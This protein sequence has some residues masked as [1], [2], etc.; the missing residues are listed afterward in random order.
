MRKK[1]SWK[2]GNGAGWLRVEAGPVAGAPGHP[3]QSE[4]QGKEVG[5]GDV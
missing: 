5:H 3:I 2:G 1:K 4:N